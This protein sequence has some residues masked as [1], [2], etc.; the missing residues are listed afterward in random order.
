MSFMK[1]EIWQEQH[2]LVETSCGT[3]I[4]PVSVCGIIDESD[5][6]WTEKELEAHFGDYCYGE[7]YSAELSSGW[8]Y[9]LSAPGYLDCTDTG[10]A[11][12]EA[13]AI[14]EIFDTWGNDEFPEEWEADLVARLRELE[15]EKDS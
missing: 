11:E 14:R 10:S 3:E 6:E 2:Y 9:R 4:I 15:S 1:P 13:E 8:L 7:I 5:E 12:S